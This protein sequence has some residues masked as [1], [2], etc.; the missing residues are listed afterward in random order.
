MRGLKI[1]RQ[2]LVKRYFN[3][4]LAE[5]QVQAILNHYYRFLN[6]DQYQM[7]LF[8]DCFFTVFS[9]LSQSMQKP[10]MVLSTD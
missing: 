3:I 5:N 9:H 4:S 7:N 10:S 1:Y 6:L 8:L 2:E